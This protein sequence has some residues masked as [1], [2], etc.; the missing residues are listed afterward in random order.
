MKNETGKTACFGL[1]GLLGAELA[2]HSGKA[3]D[4]GFSCCSQSINYIFL[5]TPLANLPVNS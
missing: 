5:M 2:P 1:T 3:V 4:K